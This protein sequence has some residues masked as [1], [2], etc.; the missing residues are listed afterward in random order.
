MR[1]HSGELHD[2]ILFSAVIPMNDKRDSRLAVV[3]YHILLSDY[4]RTGAMIRLPS[5]GEAII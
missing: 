2:R 3:G 4:I 1:H 5:V